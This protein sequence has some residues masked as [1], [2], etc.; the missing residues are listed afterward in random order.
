MLRFCQKLSD[1]ELVYIAFNPRQALNSMKVQHF[2]A[3][4]VLSGI[5]VLNP[6]IQKDALA[7]IF[8]HKEL[9]QNN[10]VAIAVPLN[11]GQY[12]FLILEQLSQTRDCWQEKGSSPTIIEPLL[13]D[14]DF[15]N[16]CGRSTDSNGYS[17]R[18]AGEDMNWRY[19]LR[20]VKTGTEI[21]LMAYSTEN[22]GRSPLEVG[23]TRGL[24]DGYLKINLN[25]GWR[26]GKRTYEDKTLGHIYL[27]NDQSVNQLVASSTPTSSYSSSASTSSTPPG[28]PDNASRTVQRNNAKTQIIQANNNQS[29]EAIPIYVPPPNGTTTSSTVSSSR[30][31]TPVAAPPPPA[32]GSTVSS[33]KT[34][35]V[36]NSPIPTFESSSSGWVGFDNSNGSAPP[37]PISRAEA[38]GLNYR[39]VV[40]ASSESQKATVKRIVPDAFNTWVDNRRMMQAGAF[41]TR[42]E[43]KERQQL[44]SQSGLK[45]QIITTR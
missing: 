26:M 17:L 7:S 39:V 29:P 5:G 22:S 15:Q 2:F 3:A 44:L 11:R 9:S 18:L 28:K 38:L 21:K 36:P 27:V 4:I 45:S 33:S 6:L 14:F 30:T 40:D 24:A 35:P 25:E 20:L 34:L 10:V 1:N 12:N 31:A 41:E 42:Q 13:L 16:I 37:P 8:D 43:A 19:N 23:S 32:V